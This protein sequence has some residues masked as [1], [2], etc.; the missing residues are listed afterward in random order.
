[1]LVPKKIGGAKRIILIIV[2][3]LIIGTIGYL[4]YDNFFADEAK[5]IKPIT[6]KVETWVAPRIDPD[7]ADDFLIKSPYIDFKER[8]KLPVRVDK[9]GRK[10]PFQKIPFGL[11]E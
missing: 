1:M 7:L 8:G 9:T 3:I 11:L 2:A 4:I 6:I 5:K 10:N